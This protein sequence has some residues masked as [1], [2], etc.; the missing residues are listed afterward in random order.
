M[1]CN[2]QKYSLS[3]TLSLFH[4]SSLSLPLFLSLSLSLSSSLCLSFTHPLSLSPLSFSLFLSLYLSPSL[5]LSFTH[6]LSLCLSPILPL[7]VQFFFPQTNAV[8]LHMCL[9]MRP[10]SQ[11]IHLI[12]YLS[13]FTLV[14][15][16]TVQF[17]LNSI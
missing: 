14:I 3:L 12:P 6:P 15:Q 16:F 10:L 9:S 1:C 7:S 8:F 2:T 5:C 11:T 13:L 4:P 17:Q